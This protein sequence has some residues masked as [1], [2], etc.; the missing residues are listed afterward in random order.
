MRKAFL[1]PTEIL[2]RVEP[3][4]GGRTGLIGSSMELPLTSGNPEV[5]VYSS[6]TAN[7]NQLSDDI[8]IL[9]EDG[10][11][12]AL[13]RPPTA[14]WHAQK[15]YEALERYCTATFNGK[16]VI[17]ATRDE[18]GESA[19]DLRL[20]ARGSAAEYQHPRNYLVAPSNQ[21]RMQLRKGIRSLPENR[22]G[23]CRWPPS[24]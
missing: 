10:L 11:P 20:F 23:R 13:D 8:L 3:F 17:V 2:E 22:P 9:S 18:L 19:V 6:Y 14:P 24:I 4:V 16:D 7:L 1:T 15:I 21:E 12:L 5:C